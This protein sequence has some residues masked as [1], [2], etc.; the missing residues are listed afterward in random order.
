MNNSN[1]DNVKI[2]IFLAKQELDLLRQDLVTEENLDMIIRYS[3]LYQTKTLEDQRQV[4]EEINEI[5][6]KETKKKL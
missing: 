3:F 1:F 2:A 5:I 4:T 6:E